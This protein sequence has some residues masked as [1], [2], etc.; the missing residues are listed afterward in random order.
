MLT[1]KTDDLS[2]TYSAWLGKGVVLLVAIRRCNIPMP[3][4]IV[5]ESTADVRVRIQSGR[6]MDIRKELI[7]AIEENTVLAETFVN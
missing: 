1:E 4:W 3:C 5:G 7:L 6:E 2:R